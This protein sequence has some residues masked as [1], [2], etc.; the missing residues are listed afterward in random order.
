[1]FGY[2]DT[3]ARLTVIVLA[4]GFIPSLIFA[5]VF[6]ITPEGL[7]KDADVDREQSITQTTGKKL[8]RIILFVLALALA[9][10]A[11]DKFVLD[12]VRDAD[13]LATAT[14]EAHQ[15]GRSE[16]LVDSYGDNSIA[17]L[18][19]VNMSSDPEQEYFSDGI[20][21]ELLNLLS[22]IPELR[23]IS[24]S[25]AFSYK[26]K[27]LDIP[28]IAAQL[29][30]AHILEGS[31]RK[32]GNRVRITAQLIEARSDT[33]LWSETYDRTLNDIFAIQDE[34]SRHIARALKVAL[35]G[36]EKEAITNA[37]K[38]TENLEAYE[39]YLRGRYLWQ[40]REEDNIRRAIELFE[41]S[42]KLDPQFAWAW[43]SLAAARIT[44]PDWSDASKEE[45]QT[46]GVFAAQKALA[47]DDSLAEA[48]AVLAA[49]YIADGKWAEAEAYYLR[50]IASEPRN[51]T[52]HMWYGELL[53]SV[54]RT[55]DALEQYLITYQLDPLHVV[56]NVVLGYIYFSLGDTNNMLKYGAASW[57]L[58]SPWG[59]YLQAWAYLLLKDFDRAIGYAGQSDKQF[60]DIWARETSLKLF[61]EAKMDANKIPLYL[62]TLTE[63][64]TTN[65]YFWF[66][67]ECYVG[68]DR[69][70]DAYR[71]VNMARDSASLPPVPW[72][73]LWRHDMAQFRQDPRFADLVTEL[74]LVD[75][76]REYGWPDACQPE[77][78]SVI[79]E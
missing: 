63:Y 46:L 24:R 8:D 74:G 48:Y 61:F 65:N 51:S 17:V 27:D 38:P 18:P 21:E 20:S 44:L 7:K 67:L 71:V 15:E 4:V 55:R 42:T 69:I 60:A 77:G 26:N 62:D 56:P 12:P 75:Y 22:R 79:C 47:L 3:P 50:A 43:S 29:N 49:P 72:W 9:Y 5:W 2:G 25:S 45:Y 33:H 11:F 52:A 16:A 6:E 36:G 66:P 39:L 58:R 37:Q 23:V 14:Q 57:D 68:F 54:G 1:L 64:E 40:R 13:E 28:T 31:V 76:W 78:D 19:F 59:L 10:F 70:D 30:V 34:I 32:A 35:I 53:V 41:R 73:I